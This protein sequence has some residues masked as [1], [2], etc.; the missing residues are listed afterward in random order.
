MKKDLWIR[1]LKR[2]LENDLWREEA[3]LERVFEKDL[4]K[5]SFRRIFKE[6]IYKTFENDL[7]S[8][9]VEIIFDENL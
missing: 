3:S 8:G 9:F 5:W 6:K 1:S 4:W 2:I 7:Y